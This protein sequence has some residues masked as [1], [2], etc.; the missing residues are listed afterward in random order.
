MGILSIYS[1]ESSKHG[2]L[3]VLIVKNTLTISGSSKYIFVNMFTGMSKL[4]RVS[5]GSLKLDRCCGGE[6][7]ICLSS[8]RKWI[9]IYIARTDAGVQENLGR[10]FEPENRLPREEPVPCIFFGEDPY[11]RLAN[12]C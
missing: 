8:F 9:K 5:D 1:L 12:T 10:I 6:L 2:M 7:L 4:L 3:L 11:V